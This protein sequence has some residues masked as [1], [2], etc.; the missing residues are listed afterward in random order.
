MPTRRLDKSNQDDRQTSL[1]DQERWLCADPANADTYK[2]RVQVV[3]KWCIER[4][5]V[6]IKKEVRKLP[7]PWTDDWIIQ[8]SRFCNSYR[9]LDRVTVSIMDNWIKPNINNP[10][11][12]IIAIFGRVINLPSTLDLLL[13][14]NFDFSRKPNSERM[15]DLFNG[16]KCKGDKLVTG[17][18]IVNTV[19]PKDFPK[20][21]G[22]KAD[23]LANF[24]APELWEKRKIVAEGLASGSFKVALD[25]MKQVHGVGAFIGNQAAVDLSYTKHL[26][27]APDIDTTWNP[28]PGTT[29]G[30][31]WV[32]GDYTLSG[33]SKKMDEALTRY[34]GD[35]N[36]ELS[37]SKLWS[38]ANS[39]MRTRVV[40]MSGP[41]ASSSLCE[42]S[43]WVAV[44]LGT[45]ERL[46]QKY[47]GT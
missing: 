28:G 30:I 15:F 34:I 29:K 46:K 43:K 5:K 17:A 19:F 13:G 33:G 32:T 6:Y 44:A 39:D 9:E 16:I 2:K 12:G 22:S 11:I 25:A 10:N 23:Y 3:A 8:G 7:A 38:S 47:K 20:M 26:L 27:N 24:L 14:H 4:H 37:R 31:R 42:I 40:P 1:F 35:L 45:R 21:D 18:Y 41:N 36:D